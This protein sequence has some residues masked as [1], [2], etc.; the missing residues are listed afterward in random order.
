MS[1]TKERMKVTLRRPNSIPMFGRLL[2]H[3][4]PIKEI[5]TKSGLTVPIENNHYIIV[6]VSNKQED[7]QIKPGS[8]VVPFQP[9]SHDGGRTILRFQVIFEYDHNGKH[10]YLVIYESELAA[11]MSVE[12][13][14]YDIEIVSSEDYEAKPQ[15]EILIPA[16]KKLILPGDKY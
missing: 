2:V 12:S 14:P 1:E 6:A 13:L 11:H 9:P 4:I 8:M 7:D 10:E 15:S 5:Y 16:A 3:P